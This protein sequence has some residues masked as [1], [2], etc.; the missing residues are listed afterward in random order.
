MPTCSDSETPCPVHGYTT[1][2]ENVLLKNTLV[3]LIKA[4]ENERWQQFEELINSARTYLE[5]QQ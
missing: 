4:W 1:E 2:D 3:G 5:R